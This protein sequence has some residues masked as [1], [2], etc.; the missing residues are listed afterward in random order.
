MFLLV[1]LYI[2]AKELCKR[3]DLREDPFHMINPLQMKLLMS[4]GVAVAIEMNLDMETV[5]EQEDQILMMLPQYLRA[6]LLGQSQRG[7][8]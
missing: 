6:Q 8:Q 4:C 5:V 2:Y 1:M 3:P 7:S